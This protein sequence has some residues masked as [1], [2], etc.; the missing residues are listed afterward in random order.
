M[1][2][3]FKHQKK[4]RMFKYFL[5]CGLLSLGGQMLAAPSS[6]ES[7]SMQ[8]T[9]HNVI[10]IVVDETG[11]PI[12]GASV[13]DASTHNGTVTNLN[14]EFTINVTTDNAKLTVSYIG[15]QTNTVS[16]NGKST[17]RIIL[18]TG[19]NELNEVVVTAL[20]IK[21]EKKALGYAMQEVKTDGLT[22]N[23]SF[24]VANMLQGKVAGVQ[25]SQSGTGLG[26]STRIVMRGLSSL[27]GKNQPLWVVDGFPI[28]DDVQS[29]A[30]Q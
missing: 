10:G 21:R 17:I 11:E 1:N 24:S 4:I 20:G 19:D 8:Q 25:I 6:T 3:D 16:V 23:K 27:S 7:Q 22:E 12:I 13:L 14:G 29:T 30:N 9:D 28:N 5:M 2:I 26:G 18:K 15:Y